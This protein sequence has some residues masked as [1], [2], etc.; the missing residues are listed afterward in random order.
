MDETPMLRAI[1][2][3]M[4]VPGHNLLF[5]WGLALAAPYSATIRPRLVHAAPGCLELGM[6]K[7]RAVSNHMGTLHAAALANLMELCGS[8]AVQLTI[9]RSARW[10]P[11]GL[12]IRYRRKARTAVRARCGLDPLDW[13]QNQDVPLQI[14]VIDEHNEVVA[15]ATLHMRIGPRR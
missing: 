3:L 11:S 15:E 5:R 13:H 8:L 10:I 1:R 9:P 12:D 7:R 2:L 14:E 4:R 6:A